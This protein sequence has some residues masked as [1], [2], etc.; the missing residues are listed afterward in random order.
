MKKIKSNM[1]FGN[2]HLLAMELRALPKV[3]K[4]SDGKTN[5][6]CSYQN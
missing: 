4:A 2:H 1:L 6:I 3:Y 5:E